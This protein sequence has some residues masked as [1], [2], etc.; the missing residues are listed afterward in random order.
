ME[1]VTM[2]TAAAVHARDGTVL[3]RAV[4]NTHESGLDGTQRYPVA[5]Y[6]EDDNAI[7]LGDSSF[8][9]ADR[10]NVGDNEAFAAYLVEFLISGEFESGSGAEPVDDGAT[11]ET[12][13]T[14]ETATANEAVGAPLADEDVSQATVASTGGQR[15][16]EADVGA[17]THI[18]G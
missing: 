17:S 15:L 8:L 11:N 16:L 13:E 14:N 18:D 7:L 1:Q 12:N 4:D 2:F 9:T 10:F 6:D 5:V 3:L